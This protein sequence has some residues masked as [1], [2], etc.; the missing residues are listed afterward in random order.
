MFDAYAVN[1]LR[2]DETRCTGCGMCLNVCPHG[3]FEARQ[4]NGSPGP[5]HGL[6]GMRGLPT[7]LPIWCDCRRK[8]G[9]MRRV[10]DPGRI[11]W[12]KSCR[13]RVNT[14]RIPRRR[15]G[16]RETFEEKPHFRCKRGNDANFE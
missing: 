6:H 2:L 1:T 13:L 7:E 10:D 9:G 5:S 11:D 8:W 3:V 16:Q 14:T 15:I 12:T 4:P